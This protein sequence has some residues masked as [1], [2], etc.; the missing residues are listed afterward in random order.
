MLDL[1]GE[2]LNLPARRVCIFGGSGRGGLHVES[3]ID[4]YEEVILP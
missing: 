3:T 1:P 4:S 2:M